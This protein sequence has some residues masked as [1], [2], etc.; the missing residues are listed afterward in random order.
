MKD[1]VMIKSNRYGLTVYLNKDL[2]FD[3]LLMEIE[4]KFRA[5]VHFFEGTGMA[6]R[7][8]NRILTKDEEQ[9]IVDVIS[10]A[11]KIQILCIL[12]YDEKTNKVYKSAVDQTLAEMPEPDGQFYR[13]TL[14]RKQV[15]ESETSIVVIG[16]VE[17]GATVVSKG[18]I[19]ITGTLYGCAHAGASGR[20]DAFIAALEMEPQRLRI[21]GR[22]VKPVIGGSYSWARLS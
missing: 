3:E 1:H 18:N 7:F 9:R 19:V 20:K 21:S 5:S 17:E 15:L 11:A 16:D 8:E 14:K 4:D 2:P 13:G 12:D 10:E 6:V 22:K